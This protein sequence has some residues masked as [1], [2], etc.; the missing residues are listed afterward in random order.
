MEQATTRVGRGRHQSNGAVE[1]EPGK[2]WVEHSSLERGTKRV[3]KKEK[4]DMG[5]TWWSLSGRA[6]S[7]FL[8]ACL[9]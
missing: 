6:C 9:L 7:V 1:W 2:E 5:L 3:K 8:S 4:K